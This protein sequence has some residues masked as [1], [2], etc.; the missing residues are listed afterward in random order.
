MI[1]DESIQ[2]S[3]VAKLKA[4]APFDTVS[5]T[6]I[7]EFQWQGDEFAYPNIRIELEKNEYE[8]DE[9]ERCQLQYIE[10]SVYA[11]SESKSSKESSRIKSAVINQLVGA[12][13]TT[14]GVKFNRV[15]LIDNVPAV[16]QDERTFRTQAKFG[17]RIQ[18]P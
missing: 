3:I 4:L 15:R 16:R 13:F 11:F 10:F 17:S 18:N 1:G 6:E 2:A 5:S 12:G 8:F 7:R 14:L 9:Q